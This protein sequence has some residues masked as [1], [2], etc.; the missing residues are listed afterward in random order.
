MQVAFNCYHDARMAEAL[1]LS[2]AGLRGF[3]KVRR[4]QLADLAVMPA[5]EPLWP[6][7]IDSDVL[8]ESFF[9]DGRMHLYGA[10][11]E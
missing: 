4:A 7:A 1:P 10:L 5:S 3:G 2:R 6:D 11:D 8:L 9:I